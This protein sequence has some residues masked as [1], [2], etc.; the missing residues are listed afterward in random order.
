M[1]GR[2]SGAA[3]AI[4]RRRLLCRCGAGLAALGTLALAGCGRETGAAAPVAAVD[5]DNAASCALDGMLLAEYP[6]PKGQ[7]QLSGQPQPEWYCDTLELLNAMLRPEQVRKRQ[8][9]W[10]QDMA[11]ADWERPRGHWIDARSAHYVL[12]SRRKGSMG[13]TAASF[14]DA[15]A[16]QAFVQQ[17]GGRVV[18]YAELKPEMVDLSGGALHDTRM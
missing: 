7:I 17:H 1:S 14:A 15:A 2:D 16:A 13:A 18:A 10:V 3:P 11:R 6:G 9:A 4:S 5:F 12:Q 8:G